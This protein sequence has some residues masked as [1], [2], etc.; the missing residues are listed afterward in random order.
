MSLDE[1]VLEGVFAGAD[2]YNSSVRWFHFTI[3]GRE[4]LT[5][6]DAHEHDGRELVEGFK[7]MQRAVGLKS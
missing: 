1:I 5:A 7:T 3:P 4:E 6:A 2:A